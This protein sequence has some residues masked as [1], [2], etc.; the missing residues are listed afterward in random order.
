MINKRGVFFIRKAGALIAYLL[1]IILFSPL[2]VHAQTDAEQVLRIGRN[3]LSMEDYVLAIQYFNQ[4]IKAKPYLADPYFFRA[5]AKV[6][7]EDYNGAKEDC[8]LAIERNKFKAESYK[9]RGFALQ[10]MGLDSLAI[11][12]YNTGLQYYPQDKYFLYYKA[13]AQ[14]ELKDFEGSE[15]TFEKLLSVFPSFEEGYEARARLNIVRGDTANALKD[16]E[17]ALSI[18]HNLINSRLMRTEIESNHKNWESA[19]KDMDEVIKLRPQD[20]GFYVN[21][22]Y[23]RYNNDDYFGAMSDYNYSLQ[24]EPDNSAALFNRALLRYEVKDLAKAADD[25]SKVLELD[26]KNFHALYN[27]GLVYLD[28]KKY[29]KAIEDFRLISKRY[30][31]FY[32]AYYALAEAR[33]AQGNFHEAMSLVNHAETLIRKYVKNPE[34]N[35]LQRPTIAA[36]TKNQKGTSQSEEESE[37]DVMNKFNRLVT[38]NSNSESRLVYN[39]KIKGQL[40]NRNVR[41]E[42]EPFYSFSFSESKTALGTITNYF[43]ELDDINSGRLLPNPVYI[44]NNRPAMSDEKQSQHLFSL[45]EMY[46]RRLKEGSLR[47]VD[48]FGRSIAY[49]V[50][51][52]YDSALADLDKAISENDNF[53]AAYMA[54]AA[55]RFEK[56][57]NHA[58]V[59]DATIKT[60]DSEMQKMLEAKSHRTE[61]ALIVSDCDK[62]LQLNPKLIFAWFNKGCIFLEE[63]DFTS[64]LEC[65][66]HAIEINPDFGEA[67]YNRG[68]TY[69]KIGNKEKAFAD[70]SKAGELGILPSYNILKRM[71]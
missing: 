50:L 5:L 1:T 62:A 18:S 46:D 36:G 52:N 66:T 39:D 24:L 51:K 49:L 55:T 71:K 14:T 16:I 23:L 8:S 19:L 26:N 38:V 2:Q 9:L 6:N 15:K 56:L 53:T 58:A 10:N 31:T 65:F 12:D 47:P 57:K 48:Y 40:Q 63:N 64:A 59:S 7:L 28:M 42:N 45:I 4:A 70:L 25:F 41:I 35:P 21:R 30:P 68:L 3:V 54:R 27:R 60:N 34:K 44:S 17:K 22:A 11:I 29:D 37:I 61:T 32:P 43:R 33:H 69:L 13:I 20:A 67:F